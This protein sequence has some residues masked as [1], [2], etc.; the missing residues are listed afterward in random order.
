MGLWYPSER[1]TKQEREGGG[2]YYFPGL[3]GCS[4]LICSVTNRA[5]QPPEEYVWVVH[6]DHAGAFRCETGLPREKY[7]TQSIETGNRRKFPK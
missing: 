2:G 1:R 5:V 3:S 6:Q 4:S 7:R